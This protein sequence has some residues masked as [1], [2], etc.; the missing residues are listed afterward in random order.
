MYSTIERWNSCGASDCNGATQPGTVCDP[1]SG[2]GTTGLVAVR[3]NRRYI[4]IELNPEYA[5]MTRTRLRPDMA[6]GRLEV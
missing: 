5:A 1:F 6:Q 4:G 3:Q 2:A